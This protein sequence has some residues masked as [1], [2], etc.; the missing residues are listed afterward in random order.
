MS[1]VCVAMGKHFWRCIRFAST[2]LLANRHFVLTATMRAN[3]ANVLQHVSEKLRG[4]RVVVRAAMGIRSPSLL[5]G[6]T[7]GKGTSGNLS[8][9]LLNGRQVCRALALSSA[10]L[11]GTRM[12][13]GQEG[14]RAVCVCLC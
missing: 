10:E 12:V 8:R 4:D 9:S 14:R 13:R 1:L 11:R 3:D 2:A 6:D 5:R 7:H